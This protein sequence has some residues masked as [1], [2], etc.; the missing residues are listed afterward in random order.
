VL[1]AASGGPKGERSESNLTYYVYAPVFCAL[2][3]SKLAAPITPGG[4]G[5]KSILFFARRINYS[6]KIID[7]INDY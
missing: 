4:I 7:L 5:S 2:S 3:V 6:L 1:N